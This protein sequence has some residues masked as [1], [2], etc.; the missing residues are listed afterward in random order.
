MYLE[1]TIKFLHGM[2][3]VRRY[4][5]TKLVN[6]ESVLEHTGFVGCL[7]YFIAKDLIN[8]GIDVNMCSLFAKAMTHDMEEVLVGDI[9]RP[10]K[11]HNSAVKDAIENLEEI[12]IESLQSDINVYGIYSD[13]NN[14]KVDM[15]G[16]IVK[17]SDCIAVVYKAYQEI[18]IFGNKAIANHIDGLKDHIGNLIFENNRIENRATIIFDE[19]LK[20]ALGLLIELEEEL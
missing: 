6:E 13:W 17:I 16:F 14:A 7:S 12:A 10:T 18:H 1:K 15:G 9:P 19:I 20:E 3:S 11:Y 5:Q 2:S 8:K 4:S